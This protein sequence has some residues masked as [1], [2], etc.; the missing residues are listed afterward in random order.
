MISK[1]KL[2]RSDKL[3][4]FVTLQRKEN[5]TNSFLKAILKKVEFF[6]HR[7]MRAKIL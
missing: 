6:P 4:S 2:F 1:A 5:E 3:L 7:C